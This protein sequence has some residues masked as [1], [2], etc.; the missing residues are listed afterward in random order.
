MTKAV[1]LMF[2]RKSWLRSLETWELTFASKQM[3]AR[4]LKETKILLA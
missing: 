1:M 3:L 4:S 2:L